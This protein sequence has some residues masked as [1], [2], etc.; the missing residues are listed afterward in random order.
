[1]SNPRDELFA[2]VI[3]L[4]DGILT[5]LALASA[6]IVGAGDPISLDLAFRISAGA[7][8]SGLFIFFVAEYARQRAELVSAELHL[9]LSSEGKL[10]VGA[11]GRSAFHKAVT[12]ATISAACSF[13]G[14]LLPLLPAALFP[15]MAWLAMAA[16]FL[17]LGILGVALSKVASANPVRWGS[18]VSRTESDDK[19]VIVFIAEIGGLPI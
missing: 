9:R 1:M 10:A 8:I 19:Q 18:R 2:I 13:S 4:M 15:K 6:R 14:S 5:A 3:G 7:A 16:A 12:G 11:L 17:A